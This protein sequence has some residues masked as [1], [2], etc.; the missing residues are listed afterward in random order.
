MT[1]KQSINLALRVI[2]RAGLDGLAVAAPNPRQA[3]KI[4]LRAGRAGLDID[5]AKLLREL[6]RQGLAH[7]SQDGQRFSFTLTPAGIHRLQEHLID[8]L[9]IPA[10]AKWDGKWRVITF[11]VP[12]RFS[13]QRTYFTQKLQALDCFMLQRSFWIHPYPCFEQVEKLAGHLNIM[14]YCALFEV[15]K[16]DDQTAERLRRRFKTLIG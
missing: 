16:F 10:P 6:K 4:A 15:S 12:V 14:R 13:K 3:L 8:E 11:D 2:G 1:T 9:A 5:S 7:I